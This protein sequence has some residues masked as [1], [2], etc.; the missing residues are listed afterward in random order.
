MADNTGSAI[1][2]FFPQNHLKDGEY[3]EF[4]NLKVKYVKG[5]LHLMEGKETSKKINYSANFKPKFSPV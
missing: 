4:R 1:G 2:S 5:V 3:Y